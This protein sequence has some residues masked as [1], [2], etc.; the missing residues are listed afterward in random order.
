MN[1]ARLAVD[2][3]GTFT[4]LVLETPRG[5]ADMQGADHAGGTR[6]R[7]ARRRARHPGRGGLRTGRGRAGRPRHDARHQCADRAQGRPHRAAH[8]RGLPRFRRDRLRAPLRPVRPHDASGPNRW[9][10]A[11]CASACPSAWP[12]TAACCC[13]STRPAVRATAADAAR[14]RASRPS[15]SCFLHS[16][17]NPAHE[18]RAAQILAEELPGVAVT[19]SCEVC[20]RDPRVRAHLHHRRQCLCAAADGGAIS[21]ALEQRAARAGIACPLLLMM[22]SGGVTTIETARRFPIRLVEIGPGRRRHPGPGRR[23]RERGSTR[24]SPSTWAAPPPRSA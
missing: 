12:P 9:C 17:A 13:R 14:A 1:H 11:T 5:A 6:T 21:A 23:G 2:I 15:R 20:A 16:F 18:R 24:C 10:R 8:H 3:G 7:R 19:L 4:D 22:S